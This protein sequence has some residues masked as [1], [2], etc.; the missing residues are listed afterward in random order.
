M[1]GLVRLSLIQIFSSSDSV[2]HLKTKDESAFVGT[3]FKS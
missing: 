2:I 1:E 3:L